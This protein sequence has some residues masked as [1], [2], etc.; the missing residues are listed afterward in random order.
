MNQSKVITIILRRMFSKKHS[1]PLAGIHRKMKV[2]KQN[3]QN[4]ENF[5]IE[6][7]D[8]EDLGE[9]ESD[10]MNVGKSHKMHE[11]YLYFIFICKKN[12]YLHL[13]CYATIYFFL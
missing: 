3:D 2:M 13:M 9:F 10:F 4:I 6:S 5:D 7:F 12:S 8:S 11:W 1:K